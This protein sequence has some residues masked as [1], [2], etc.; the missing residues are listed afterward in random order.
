MI[1]QHRLLFE[2]LAPALRADLFDYAGADL[3]GKGRLHEPC[4]RL[5]APRAGH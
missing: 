3:A 5:T 4:A 1:D 2:P